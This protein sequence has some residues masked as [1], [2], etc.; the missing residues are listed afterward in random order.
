MGHY[1][2]LVREEEGQWMILDYD[3]MKEGIGNKQA[4]QMLLKW[5]YILMYRKSTEKDAKVKPQANKLT[6]AQL[7]QALAGSMPY[8]KSTTFPFSTQ[9]RLPLTKTSRK[10][11]P[12]IKT[13]I[14]KIEELIPE[15]ITTKLS[16]EPYGYCGLHNLG[17]LHQCHPATTIQHQQGASLLCR[18]YS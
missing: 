16:I 10:F 1:S 5:A 3:V 6:A 12:N 14:A 9:Q 18:E 2:V 15:A 11:Q 13:N 8:L 17:M 7:Q 4:L